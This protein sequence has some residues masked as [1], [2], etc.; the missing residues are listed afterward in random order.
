MLRYTRSS[1]LVQSQYNCFIDFSNKIM[2][3][4]SHT[5]PLILTTYAYNFLVWTCTDDADAVRN[6]FALLNAHF[7]DDCLLG[8]DVVY[9]GTYILSQ[10]TV[11]HPVYVGIVCY[12]AVEPS[13]KY[14]AS[15]PRLQI[16]E[17]YGSEEAGYLEEL[18]VDGTMAELAGKRKGWRDVDCIL[19]VQKRPKGKWQHFVNADYAFLKIT[20]TSWPAKIMSAS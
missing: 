15:H 20:G 16:W 8:Y 19:L 9:V 11:K 7:E 1:C 13:S 18:G 17:R 4:F 14:T 6:V 3:T 5:F 10:F 2:M 12:E